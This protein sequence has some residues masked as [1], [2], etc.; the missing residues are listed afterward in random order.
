MSH[1]HAHASSAPTNSEDDSGVHEQAAVA[2]FYRLAAH[3]G[4]T[5]I[6]G[7]HLD[8]TTH[9]ADLVVYPHSVAAVIRRWIVPRQDDGLVVIQS[10]GPLRVRVG[11]FPPWQNTVVW[12]R[13]DQRLVMLRMS[14][15]Q[16][17]SLRSAL[18]KTGFGIQEIERR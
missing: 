18:T 1:A 2:V 6:G 16:R 7:A 5:A 8:D 12:V 11:R 9:L 15:R 3:L 13:H 14:G 4:D 17:R 10:A